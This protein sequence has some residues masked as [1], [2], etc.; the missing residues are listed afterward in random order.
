[1]V[2]LSKIILQGVVPLVKAIMYF[3]SLSVFI[4]IGVFPSKIFFFLQENKK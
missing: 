4:I 3:R 2:F 1:M